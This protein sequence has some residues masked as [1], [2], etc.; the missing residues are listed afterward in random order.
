[1]ALGWLAVVPMPE[2]ALKKA[3]RRAVPRLA[4]AYIFGGLLGAAVGVAICPDHF[5]ITNMF[6][7]ISVYV[8]YGIVLRWLG[9]LAMTFSTPGI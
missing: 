1:M 8:L 5:T 3:L 2:G 6:R 9:S 4:R 7:H